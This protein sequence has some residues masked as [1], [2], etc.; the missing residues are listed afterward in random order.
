MVKLLAEDGG[1]AAFRF[2]AFW[3]FGLDL[4]LLTSEEFLEECEDGIEPHRDG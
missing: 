2:S 3:R 1:G 4:W